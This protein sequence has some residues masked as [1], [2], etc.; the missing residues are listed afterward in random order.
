MLG[1]G[2]ERADAVISQRLLST[3]SNSARH[4]LEHTSST[5]PIG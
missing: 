5:N 1:W 3:Q 2:I 4:V